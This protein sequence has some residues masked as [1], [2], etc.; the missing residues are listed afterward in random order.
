MALVGGR[1]QSIEH[2]LWSAP[3]LSCAAQSVAAMASTGAASAWATQPR[4]QHRSD[5]GVSCP[6]DHDHLPGAEK[7]ARPRPP[8]GEP[9][10]V[11]GGLRRQPDPSTQA[12]GP[13][14]GESWNL[15]RPRGGPHLEVKRSSPTIAP[16]TRATG[17]GRAA[18]G[19]VLTAARTGSPDTRPVF[20][21]D[22]THSCRGRPSD[23]ISRRYRAD[24]PGRRADRIDR[25]VWRRNSA[26]RGTRS[27]SPTAVPE[28][29]FHVKPMGRAS[30]TRV[31]ARVATRCRSR[32]NNPRSWRWRRCHAWVACRWPRGIGTPPSSSLSGARMRAGAARVLRWFWVDRPNQRPSRS[33]AA[34]GA[35]PSEVGERFRLRGPRSVPGELGR[36]Q[37][38]A[39]TPGRN[40]PLRQDAVT[41]TSS[42]LVTDAIVATTAQTCVG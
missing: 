7:S 38:A 17:L 12:R 20:S 30:A 18:C 2:A 23:S 28:H 3:V 21:A 6:N 25:R 42:R 29:V 36:P 8:C 31:T 33:S 1:H 14:S 32:E 19:V 11:S 34:R 13:A 35:G 10:H 22:Q 5:Q 9:I 40:R 41:G 15:T 37:P 27:Q 16:P 39:L 4:G 26:A 24:A